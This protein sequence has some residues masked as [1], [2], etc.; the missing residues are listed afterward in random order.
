MRRRNRRENELQYIE[1]WGRRRV[2]WK[3]TDRRW[4]EERIHVLSVTTYLAR[5]FI[6]S[7]SICRFFSGSRWTRPWIS[8]ILASGLS[9]SGW[10]QQKNIH[11][12]TK[13]LHFLSDYYSYFYSEQNSEVMQKNFYHEDKLFCSKH[14]YRQPRQRQMKVFA[15]ANHRLILLVDEGIVMKRWAERRP[16][17]PAVDKLLQWVT[18]A[19]PIQRET[20]ED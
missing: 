9:S 17:R 2:K 16:E 4:G 19:V 8:V 7:S 20:T 18:A 5:C 11:C 12:W 13:C 15:L 3:R 1:R 10:R 14:R 6:S